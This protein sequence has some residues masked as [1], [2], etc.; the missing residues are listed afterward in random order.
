MLLP[1][2][3]VLGVEFS[4]VACAENQRRFADQGRIGDRGSDRVDLALERAETRTRTGIAGQLTKV[5][6]RDSDHKPLADLA[7]DSPFGVKI[8]ST[9]IIGHII[10]E[11]EGNAG[12]AIE[13][14]LRGLLRPSE[15]TSR[16]RSPAGS[17]R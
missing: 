5:I 13:L 10:F 4:I 9:V 12:G 6:T 17:N 11:I 2:Q 15:T 7:A 16:Y 1:L 3:P 14:Q 8:R